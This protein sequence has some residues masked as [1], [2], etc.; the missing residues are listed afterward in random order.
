MRAH[1]FCIA[2]ASLLATPAFAQESGP[3]QPGVPIAAD[4][5]GDRIT[6]GAGVATVP[7]YEGSDNNILIPAAAVQ[8]TISGY[9]F[10]TRGASLYVDVFRNDTG[11]A[12]DFQLGPVVGVNRNRVNR[13]GDSQVRALGKRKTAVDVGGYVGIGKTGVIT[14]DYDTLSVNVAYVHDVASVYDSYVITP[15]INYGTPL[16]RFAFVGLTASA[17][18]AGRGYASTYFDVDTAGA[19]RSGLPRYN[20]GKGWKN[21]TVG[22][23]GLH[24]LT[25]DLTGGLSVAAGVSYT[26]L[27]NDFADSP[28]TSVA[29][30]RNQLMGA[31]G[32]AYTF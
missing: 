15:Q 14:S 25:G 17:S 5:G 3:G 24:S 16:S 11:P 21:W 26:R 27:L 30:S 32:L 19:L 23:L 13:I 29:G 22:V 2:A 1:S 7:S 28:V 18:Y 4:A 6:V 20:A 10:S 8:G 31:L 12:W 9:S